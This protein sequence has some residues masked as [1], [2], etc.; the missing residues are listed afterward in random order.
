[1]DFSLITLLKATFGG[2]GWGFGLSGFVPLI[3]PSV[4]LTTHVMYSG[5]A[6]GAAVLASLYIFAAWKSR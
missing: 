4:E 3:A 6:W 2:A 5:A 1:M